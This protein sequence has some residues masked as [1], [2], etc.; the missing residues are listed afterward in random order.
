MLNWS[1]SRMAG[2]CGALNTRKTGA[3]IFATEQAI[4]TQISANLQLNLTPQ[5]ERLLTK[6]HTDNVA[7]YH[8]YLKGKYCWGKRTREALTQ[9]VQSFRQAIDLDPTY[10]LAYAGLGAAYTPMVFYGHVHP[11]E[12]ML[13][14]KA[15]ARKALEIDPMLSEART[16]LGGVLW[17]YDRDYAGAERELRAVI[18]TD[19]NYPWA[20]Q[21]LAE[22]LTSR[23]QFAEAAEETRR[24]LEI[25]SSLIALAC[26]QAL[27]RFYARRYDEAVALCRRTIE[28]E[29][30]FYLRALDPWH[31]VRTAGTVQPKPS[32]RC[33]RHRSFPTTA[34]TSSQRSPARTRRRDTKPT[35][36]TFS[37]HWSSRRRANTSPRCSRP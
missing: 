14:G 5:S 20:R 8:L 13:T 21:L 6:R 35:R 7:A 19:P 36:A 18:A 29:A 24:A 31:G 37:A 15:A 12:G 2:S 26:V 22:L 30:T 1:T 33:D 10:A 17:S 23:G 11:S 34:R 3:D 27:E 9:A 28:M 25:E 16:M 4:A 32:P